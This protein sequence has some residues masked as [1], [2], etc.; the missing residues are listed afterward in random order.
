MMTL[1][2][3]AKFLQERD[4]FCI[5]THRRPDGD[6]LGS[7]GALCR[8]LHLAGKRAWILNNP[9]A[10]P[11]YAPL[12]RGLTVENPPAGA[13]LVCVDVAAPSMLPEE[14]K[15]YADR[16]R[17]RIDHHAT[18]TSF[19]EH[20]L[21]DFSRASCAEIIY[22][23][24]CHMGV[25]MDASTAEAVYT[26]AATDTGCFRFSNT[27]ANTHRVAAAC[28]EAGADVYPI[29]KAH[30]DT[31]SLAKLRLQ[32]WMAENTRF[33]AD[34]KVAVCALPEAVERQLGVTEDD[35][36]SISGFPQSI[37]GVCLSAVLRELDDGRVKISMRAIPGYD[38]AKLCREFGGGGHVSAAGATVDLPLMQAAEAAGQAL[39]GQI[40]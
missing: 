40:K 4:N 16:I 19:A 11:K 17:L 33:Y 27:T 22:D 5:L 6:T 34:G 13:V 12:I 31:V 8:G 25:Q 18:A 14:T 24:L 26:G 21:V 32:G 20:E 30:F 3:C 39:L 15:G 28:I 29:N 36:E 7:A 9:E 2:E 37:E 38:V 23:L 1:S 35:M 10:A